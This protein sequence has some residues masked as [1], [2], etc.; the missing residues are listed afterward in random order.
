MT[1]PFIIA[2]DGP[3]GAGKSTLGR[4]LARELGLLYIDTGAMYRAVALAAAAAG[5]DESDA[6]RLTEVAH[7]ARVRL[8]GDPDSLRVYLDGRDVSEEIRGEGVGRVASVVSAVPGVRRELV[9]RQR[10]LGEAGAGCV[11]DGRDVG[12]VVFPSADVKFFLTAVPEARARRRLDEERARDRAPTFEATLAD[13]NERDYRDA[14]RVDSP[15]RI[16]DDAVVIDTTELSVEEVFQRMLRAVRDRHP[17]GGERGR[18][19]A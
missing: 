2:I 15:L 4:R 11:L 6:D 17:G 13:I 5:V 19:Q 16:A 18:T 3:S 10:E 7:R 8:E 12:T 1:K 14:T 9:R